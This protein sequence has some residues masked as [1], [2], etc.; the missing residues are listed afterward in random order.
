VEKYPAFELSPL[1]SLF[2][3]NRI[4]DKIIK[5]DKPL[6]DS[7]RTEFRKTSTCKTENKM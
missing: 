1:V 4:V 7:Y 2:L 3:E 6:S 5:Y